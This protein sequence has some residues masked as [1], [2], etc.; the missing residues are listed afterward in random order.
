[1]SK[2]FTQTQKQ[3]LNSHLLYIYSIVF[4]FIH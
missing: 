4:I 3:A 2:Y 1:M